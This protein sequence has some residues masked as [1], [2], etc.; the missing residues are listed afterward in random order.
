MRIQYSINTNFVNLTNIYKFGNMLI[1]DGTLFQSEIYYE[2]GAKN[3]L[4]SIPVKLLVL[5]LVAQIGVSAGN[6]SVGHP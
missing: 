2:D 4:K 6:E 3:P 1:V 5:A